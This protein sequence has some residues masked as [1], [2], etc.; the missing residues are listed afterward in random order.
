VLDLSFIT[1]ALSVLLS[2]FLVGLLITLGITWWM[3][4]AMGF[5]PP[6]HQGS[7]R[8]GAFASAPRSAVPTLLLRL[9]LS[10]GPYAASAGALYALIFG[11]VR[12]R[13]R[14]LVF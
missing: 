4:T 2:V 8:A 3:A 7:E 10:A 6:R 9:M 13:N 1:S 11:F 14:E 12:V 5:S